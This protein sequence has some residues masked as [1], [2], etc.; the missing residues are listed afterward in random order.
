MFHT[1]SLLRVPGAMVASSL[2]ALASSQDSLSPTPSPSLLGVPA[3]EVASSPCALASSLGPLSL[4][5]FNLLTSVM[6]SC[7]SSGQPGM[8]PVGRDVVSGHCSTGLIL[9][10]GL[11]TGYTLLTAESKENPS[12][13]PL[14]LFPPLLVWQG[15]EVQR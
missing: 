3:A 11:V 7:F 10:V 2:S 4:P 5:E 1:L 12:P 8:S 6:S 15:E 14:P 13:L 9:G